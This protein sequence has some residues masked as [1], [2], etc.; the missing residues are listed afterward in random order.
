MNRALN[1]LLRRIVGM[2]VLRG[3]QA[4]I[5]RDA[6][7]KDGQR[8]TKSQEDTM[9]QARQSVKMLRRLSRF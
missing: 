2:A 1:T 7:P 4:G 8:P 6:G 5:T 3:V 9:K